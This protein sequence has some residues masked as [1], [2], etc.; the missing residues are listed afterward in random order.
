[1]FGLAHLFV[2]GKL[3]LL[4]PLHS[5][6]PALETSCTQWSSMLNSLDCSGAS[7]LV[8]ASQPLPTCMSVVPSQTADQVSTEPTWLDAQHCQ[9]CRIKFGL[10]TRKHHW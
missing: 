5:K 2:K 9:Q 4:R 3:Q 8:L 7:L 1:M 6:H 10:A